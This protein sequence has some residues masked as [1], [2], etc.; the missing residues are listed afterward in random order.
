LTIYL[1][2]VSVVT[3]SLNQARFLEKTIESVLS[4][5]YPS[6]EY[7][8]VDG[9]STDGSEAI[10]RRHASRLAL[11]VSEA[12]RG[13]TDA[14]NKG[15]THAHGDILAW[16]NSDDTWTPR[17]VAC[18]V[19]AFS[20]QL[21]YGLIYGGANYIDEDDC[22]IGRF[23]AAQTTY[24]LLRQGY[25][26]IP[27]QAAFFRA[28]LWRSLGPLDA[29]LY[30]AMDYDLWV[31]IAQQAPIKYVPQIWANFRLHSAGKTILA[32]ERCWPEMLRIHYRDG[33]S[34]FS[35]IVAKYYI[36]RLAAPLLRWRRRR[37]MGRHDKDGR[38]R[39]A[40]IS[41]SRR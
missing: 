29:S 6:L 37:L 28:D 10:I 23:P 9:G 8:V 32:D 38:S 33:G 36:R 5:D 30:F 2:L 22:I 18:A 41:I 4:Q 17:T 11:W 27:Q 39:E 1:P 7:I 31:R 20:E 25:V 16:L 35:I 14:I 26:H 21:D 3:P 13:Q 19:R 15:F 24:G 34:F 40:R 12:D